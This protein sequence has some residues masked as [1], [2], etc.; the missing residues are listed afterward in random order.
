[1]KRKT[2]ITWWIIIQSV[3]FIIPIMVAL[4]SIPYEIEKDKIYLELQGKYIN[5]EKTTDFT[6]SSYAKD[7][8]KI[9]DVTNHQQH[10]EL[11]YFDGLGLALFFCLVLQLMN[12]FWFVQYDDM[13]FDD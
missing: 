5:N 9:A 7:I 8:D 13:S 4:I 1:M 11:Y 10:K 2:Y 3:L 6:E 12:I